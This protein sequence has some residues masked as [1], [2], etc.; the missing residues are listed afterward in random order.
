MTLTSVPGIR[1]GHA[2]HPDGG[3]GCTV[4]IGP[5]RGAV[6]VS[7]MAT[8]T[9]DLGALSPYHIVEEIH[10]I[11]LTGGSAYGLAAADGVMGWL[12]EQ[13]IGF[14]TGAALV[15]IV[16]AAVIFDLTEESPRP[17]A[18][19]GRTA[20]TAA[21][22]D[23]VQSGRVG[24]GTGATVG[25]LGGREHADPG[26]LGSA[27]VRAGEYTVSALS[28][29]NAV[30]D[31]LGADGGVIAGGGSGGGALFGAA[32]DDASAGTPKPLQNTTLSVIATD[33]PLSRVDLG[34]V[35]RM[36]STG[37]ARR[38]SPVNTPYDGDV[39]FAVSAVRPPADVDAQTVLALG[40]AARDA[41]EL[42]IEKAVTAD[43]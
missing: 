2:T 42:A 9:R 32:R 14:A 22:S 40:V 37:L 15:P 13:G 19:L 3:T 7:G 41:L 35:A 1:V 17:D 5:F 24:A 33:A 18:A 11:L 30:G 28:V 38:I 20:C 16:P 6:H 21:T 4:V 34:R 27:S 26:G 23:P 8:G 36:A 12:E 29:V 31:V 25:K 39:T 43:T 10:A